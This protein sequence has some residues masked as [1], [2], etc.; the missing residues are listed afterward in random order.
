MQTSIGEP[1]PFKEMSKKHT[2]TKSYV[3]ERKP[4]YQHSGSIHIQ[5]IKKMTSETSI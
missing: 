5:E 3:P 4:S 1:N 2:Y